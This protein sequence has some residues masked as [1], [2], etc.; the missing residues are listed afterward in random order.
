VY[1]IAFRILGS[2]H[3]AEDVS[4]D[5]F[6][7]ALELFQH[8]P[9]R[10]WPGLLVRL[11]TVRSIDRLRRRRPSVELS[12]AD[13]LTQVVPAHEAER[14]ELAEQ[15][16]QA[17]ARLPERQAAVF[18]LI[19]FEQLSRDEVAEGLNISP[20]AVSTALYKA[21]QRLSYELNY[22]KTGDS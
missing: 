15:L 18:T 3:D 5:V 14:N 12:E 17:I 6:V 4:Q 1:R 2:V 22:L 11:A 10:S 21:R 8:Q 7:E 9:V 19:A 16:R 13:H 20:E